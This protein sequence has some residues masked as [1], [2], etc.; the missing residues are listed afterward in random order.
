MSASTL[1]PPGP[2]GHWLGGNLPD[3]RRDRLGYLTRMAREYGDV[4][5]LRFAHR[6][7]L[8]VSHPDLIEEV[9]VHRARHFIKHFA[10]RLNPLVLGKGLL[11]SEGDFWLKQRRLIQPAFNK[12][13]LAGYAPA[14]VAAAERRLNAWL[15]GERRDIQADMMAITLEIAAQT[16]FGAEA[17]DDAEE[18]RHALDHLQQNFV[19]RFNSLVPWPLW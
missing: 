5:A 4:V 1:C 12:N 2:K 16:L 15:P 11:T 13:R 18:V 8:L 19:I 7:I 17:A 14:M 3:F 9:L 10:M 6:H